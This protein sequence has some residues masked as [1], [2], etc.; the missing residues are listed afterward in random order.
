MHRYLTTNHQPITDN[1]KSYYS[2]V[3]RSL[4]VCRCGFLPRRNFNDRNGCA[5][6]LTTGWLK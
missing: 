4:H 5:K 6:I 3:G 2:R 1:Q